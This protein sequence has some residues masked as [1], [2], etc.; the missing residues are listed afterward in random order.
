MNIQK[1]SWFFILGLFSLFVLF[2]GTFLG[3]RPLNIP[4]EGRYS[5]VA[6]E[7]LI[8]GD[9]IT[10]RVNG[11]VFFDKPPLNYW[12]QALSMKAFGVNNLAARLPNVLLGF[13]GCLIVYYSTYK[14][15][16]WHRAWLASCI[17]VT[18]PLYFFASFYTDM[19]L[20]MAIFISASLLLFLVS[21]EEANLST[22]RNLL[23][24]AYI[25]VGLAIL[26]KGLIGIVIPGCV[27]GSWVLLQRR[28]SL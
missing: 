21:T 23:F 15:Y 14:L 6:R 4:D 10:P 17:L 27:I 22:K 2:Y 3:N 13:L 1:K 28:W 12:L 9:Y 25:C 7:M 19:N 20:P 18:M 8:T 24:G 16:G 26:T 11:L 5:E